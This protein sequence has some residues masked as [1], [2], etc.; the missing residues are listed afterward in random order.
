MRCRRTWYNNADVA[1][2][3]D[4]KRNSDGTISIP[5]PVPGTGKYTV[6]LYEDMYAAPQVNHTLDVINDGYGF[7]DLEAS[8]RYV[9]GADR[10]YYLQ[11]VFING[12]SKGALTTIN[13][14]EGDIAVIFAKNGET[15][16]T[17]IC[18]AEVIEPTRKPKI[19]NL[20]SGIPPSRR[21][22]SQA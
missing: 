22:L 15:V 2:T 19:S 20:A 11:D 9:V 18:D 5:I 16:D 7:V 3:G 8:S 17:G 10:G 6:Y 21:L 13:V 4:C 14:S 12:I 1:F